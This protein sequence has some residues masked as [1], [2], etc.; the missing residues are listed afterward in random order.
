M[1]KA[2]PFEEWRFWAGFTREPGWYYHA[3]DL[4][5]VRDE[6][7][8]YHIVPRVSLLDFTTIKKL[9]AGKVVVCR[10][11]QDWETIKAFADRLKMPWAGQGLPSVS[12]SAISKSRVITSD[13]QRA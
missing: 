11:P 9:T 5:E 3:G 10:V 1:S 4:T 2:P 8:R 12:M 13:F 7:L 6:M